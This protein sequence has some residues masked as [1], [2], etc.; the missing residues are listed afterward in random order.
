MAEP[1]RGKGGSSSTW[2]G[3]REKR[4]K[5]ESRRGKRNFRPDQKKSRRYSKRKKEKK[6]SSAAAKERKQR[7]RVHEREKMWD[8][9]RGKGG[10][11]CRLSADG[12]GFFFFGWKGGLSP[13][14]GEI[15]Y[16]AE[17][18]I[19]GEKKKKRKRKE[20]NS[21]PLQGKQRKGGA[22]KEDEGRASV[23]GKKVKVYL[24]IWQ[25]EGKGCP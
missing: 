3:G 15:S 9:L 2:G 19:L 10:G 25:K 24:N 17:R 12:F 18:V 13:I 11:N 4:P 16:A 1:K 6:N 21:F 5:L 20:G 8:F 14:R 23:A 7:T 22:T